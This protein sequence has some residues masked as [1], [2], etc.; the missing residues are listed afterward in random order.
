[1]FRV[2]DTINPIAW[3]A[4]EH[5]PASVEPARRPAFDPDDVGAL[6]QVYSEIARR[7]SRNAYTSHT[8]AHAR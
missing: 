4:R 1:M 6:T 7:L 2:A 3:F 5:A 8:V